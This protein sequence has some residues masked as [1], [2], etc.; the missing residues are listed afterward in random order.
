MILMFFPFYLIVAR[1]VIPDSSKIAYVNQ[2]HG[3]KAK[4]HCKVSRSNP[5]PTI[6]WFYQDWPCKEDNLNG[7]CVPKTDQWR[8]LLPSSE[9]KIQHDGVFT[10][11]ITLSSES[12]AFYMC[13]AKNLLGNAS[14]IFE[15]HRYSK[16]YCEFRY[17]LYL[18]ALP[19]IVVVFIVVFD[20]YCYC[21]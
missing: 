8:S 2:K 6:K 20:I 14:K 16:Y 13:Q 3:T 9:V 5:L 10:S 19:T 12:A 4:I 7:N 21:D 11:V 17:R 1:P 15:F 18:T